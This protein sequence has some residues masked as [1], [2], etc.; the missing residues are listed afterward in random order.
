[1]QCIYLNNHF[2]LQRL[3]VELAARSSSIQLVV[4]ERSDLEAALVEAR[5]PQIIS[6]GDTTALYQVDGRG[7]TI[8]HQT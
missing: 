7:Q 5:Y 4:A 1:M 3:Q 2:Q 8:N 6:N